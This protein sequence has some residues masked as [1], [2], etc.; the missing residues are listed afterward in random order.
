MDRRLR[1]RA[2]G[3][4]RGG[5]ARDSKSVLFGGARRRRILATIVFLVALAAV[6]AYW[7]IVR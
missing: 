6:A 7:L 1:A 2:P 3:A 5:I 4:V